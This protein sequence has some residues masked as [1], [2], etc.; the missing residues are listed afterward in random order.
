LEPGQDYRQGVEI[1]PNAFL[2]GSCHSGGVQTHVVV[3]LLNDR[4][5]GLERKADFT[6]SFK[7]L[8][9]LRIVSYVDGSFY[10]KL[11]E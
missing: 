10:Y 1:P 9:K 3:T 4:L 2:Q 8:Q 11:D 7:K 6:P 5:R